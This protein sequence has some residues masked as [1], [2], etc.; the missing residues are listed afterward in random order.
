VTESPG[1]FGVGDPQ[2]MPLP[3]SH[4]VA[5]QVRGARQQQRAV[6]AAHALPSLSRTPTTHHHHHH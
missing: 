1:T 2:T 6:H 4:G 3:H 5:I